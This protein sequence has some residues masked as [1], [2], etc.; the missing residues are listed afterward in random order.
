MGRGF[1]R[2]AAALI[3]ASAGATLFFSAAAAASPL[4]LT[5]DHLVPMV[6]GA[7]VN[8]AIA[9]DGTF[10]TSRT[11]SISTGAIQHFDDEG[12]DLGDGFD[13]IAYPL[14]IGTDANHVYI[15]NGSGIAGDSLLSFEPAAGGT[16]P[17]RLGSD[18]ETD[19][20]LGSD[21]ATLRVFPGGV[22]AVAMGQ[23]D[24]VA[25]MDLAVTSSEHPFYPQF[26]MGAGIN[27]P[28]YES[29]NTFESC[30][31]GNGGPV[32]GG[33]PAKCGTEDGRVGGLDYPDDVAPVAGG[34]YVTELFGNRVTHLSFVEAG[35]VPD[36]E[37]G[38]G[39]GSSGGQLSEPV[40]IVRQA[41]SGD[42]FVSEQGNRRIS[43]FDQAGGYLDSFG[44][45]VR[46]G[47]DTFE[48]CGDE[49][50]ACQAGVDLT[51]DPHS[52]FT[53]L[54]FGPEGDLYAYMPLVNQVQ[55]FAVGGG[56]ASS[57]PP[58]SGGPMSPA[59]PTPGPPAPGAPPTPT[60]IATAP[61]DKVNLKVDPLKV[62]AGTTVDLTAKVRP[63]ATCRTRTVRFQIKK[64]AGWVNLGGKLKPDKSCQATAKIKV[65]SKTVFRVE[66]ASGSGA[67]LAKSPDVTVKLKG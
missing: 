16:E 49:I 41:S 36:F 3:V 15:T 21:Q 59:S 30:A 51:T 23:L 9:S 63:T 29:G 61:A 45:G 38:K 22:A 43:V 25:T 27:V 62:E 56:S 32:A 34:L 64:G 17:G 20:R 35:V 4:S 1:M 26:F 55:V 2:K 5:P 66:L 65:T 44:Y 37:F 60:P 42:L 28:S 13:V 39:P 52:Y 31:V 12:D 10:W 50:G 53:R 8:Y 14:G 24:K 40:S 48:A 54:D 18:L 57:P 58:P 11:T 46:D 33:E 47:A 7:N 19:E 6:A 67:L